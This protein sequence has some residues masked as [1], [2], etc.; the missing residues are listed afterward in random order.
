MKTLFYIT[1][2]SLVLS[3]SLHARGSGGHG[4]SHGGARRPMHGGGGHGGRAHGHPGH[5]HWGNHSRGHG[6]GNW[7]HHNWNGHN[8]RY[9]NGPYYYNGF[10]WYGLGGAFLV[11]LT[12]YTCAELQNVHTWQINNSD[13]SIYNSW[14]EQGDLDNLTLSDSDDPNYKYLCNGNVCIKIKPN[15]N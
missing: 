14:V 4:G 6:R 2:I 12:F 3:P 10:G 7:G 8:Y 13:I 5:G 1:V 11:G 15:S 9:W